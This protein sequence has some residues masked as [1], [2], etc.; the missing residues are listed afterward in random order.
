MVTTR[1]AGTS[2][3]P[4][5]GAGNDA[6]A[7]FCASCGAGLLDTCPACGA[8]TRAGAQFCEACGHRLDRPAAPAEE[9]R[10]VTVLFAD[11]TGST[12]LGEQLDPE[13]LRVLLAEYFG[14]MASVIESWGGTV[15]KFVGDAVMAVFGIPA[16]HE[17]DP[18]R[19]LRAALDMQAR[20]RE[21]NPELAKRHGVELAMR[22]GVNTGEVL[23]G[24]GGDQF[25]V[26][27]DAVNVAARLQ[28]TAEPGEISAGERTYLAAQGGFV[29]EPLDGKTVKGKSLPVS[30][31][32]LIES[33]GP[34]R[35]RG[36]PGLSARFVGREAEVALLEMLY[37]RAVD[38]RR[39]AL[40]TILGQAGIGKTRLTEELVARAEAERS[41]IA[42]YRGRCLPYGQGITYWALREILWE[43]TGI[44]LDDPG[45]AAA[46]KLGHFVRALLDGSPSASADA[47]RTLYALAASAGIALAENPLDELSPESIGEE[48]GLAWPRLVTA[49]AA[50]RPTIV[51][52]ED[53]HWAEPPLLDMI[54]HLVSRSSGPVLVLTTARPEFTELR[55][56]WSSRPAI[57]QIALEPLTDQ[58]SEEL[59]GELLPAVSA[60]LRTKVLS[61]AEGNPFFAE[62]IVRHLIDSGVLARDDGHVSEVDPDAPVTIPDTVRALLAARVDA[63][64]PD[65]K[66]ALQDAAVVGRVFWTTALEALGTDG[67]LREALRGL[68]DRG[69]V[70]TRASSSLPGQT[71]LAFRHGLTRDVAYDTIPRAR[72]APVHADVGRWIEELAGDR[73]DEYVDLIAYHF[74]AAARAEDAAL[75]WPEEAA[76]RERLRANAVEALLAA[77]RAAKSR[78]EIDQALGFGARALALAPTQSERLATLELRAEA[79]ASGVRADEAWSSYLEALELAEEMEAADVVARLRAQATL[80]WSRYQG[81]FSGG[82]W[83]PQAIAIVERGLQEAAEGSESFTTGALLVGRAAMDHWRLKPTE[84]RTARGDAERAIEIAESIKSPVLLSYAV[85]TLAALAGEQGFCDAADLARQA[86]HAGRNMPDRWSGHEMLVTAAIF[87]SDAGRYEEAAE[88]AAEAGEV[89]LQLGTHHRLHSA[90]AQTSALLPPGRL[91]ELR[92]ATAEAADLVAEEGMH[93]CFHGLNALGAQALVAFEARDE[94]AVARA[95]QVIEEAEAPDVHT[96]YAYRLVDILRPLLARDEIDRWLER[97]E[98]RESE[99]G[100]AHRTRL[101]LQVRALDGDWPGV[102]A[103][104]QEARELARKTCAPWLDYLVEWSEA[105]RLAA[106]GH[107]GDALAKGMAAVEALDAYG[108]RYRAARLQ[109]ELLAALEG[110]AARGLAADVA[111]RLEAMGALASAAKAKAL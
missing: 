80:F 52:V 54:E 33:S 23:A 55:P 68:E 109:V 74:E 45:A 98:E 67:R 18:E 72:R 37:R 48:L 19:A 49:L 24:S 12:T 78:F 96:G 4:S 44:L 87:Y 34:M 47:D 2:A 94:A 99:T 10:L 1:M 89:G 71:E 26:T 60:E 92:A 70:V 83:K 38:E 97:I 66:R 56:A 3:C 69:L 14:A 25:M 36:V 32:R 7:R 103:A 107:P 108:E 101:E 104:Q 51:I 57:S 43:A 82:E 35:P 30:A 40:V 21:M 111:S 102:A 91:R 88:V 11:L 86:L 27:G 79:A 31:W 84:Y 13:R 93:T 110:E 85:D 29:F 59:V 39:P 76:V 17:D 8:E 58:H 75:A 5:C 6:G 63:L 16:V 42:V 95:L 46:E 100:K 28:Q 61:A 50:Q 81:A 65:Q 73:R 106:S 22:I 9:R 77:G 41:A 53:L 90:A 15:E 20:L 64:P 105:M 62:E